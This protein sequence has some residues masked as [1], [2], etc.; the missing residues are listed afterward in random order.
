MFSLCLR[1]KRR[2]FQY[3]SLQSAEFMAT[4]VLTLLL[5]ITR[6]LSDNKESEENTVFK[7]SYLTQWFNIVKE[8]KPDIECNYH[9]QKR[10]NFRLI[11]DIDENSYHREGNYIIESV[12]DWWRYNPLFTPDRR[13]LTRGV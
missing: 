9:W 13:S 3:K 6:P 4:C 5:S 12:G 2:L 8:S 11:Y 10:A 1:Y 7:C